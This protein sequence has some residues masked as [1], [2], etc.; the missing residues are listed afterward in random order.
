MLRMSWVCQGYL[1][2]DIATHT[3]PERLARKWSSPIYA[4]YHP[5]PEIEYKEGRRCHTFSC[6][7]KSCK[8]KCRRYLDKGD[9]NST[10]NLRKHV[11]TCWGEEALRAA[12]AT[13]SVKVARESVVKSLNETGSIT[14]AFERKGKGKVTYSNR[15]HTRTETRYAFVGRYPRAS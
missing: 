5:I 10:G 4:F 8:F 2:I 14:A 13:A 12:E 6:A 7:S 11:K 15:Q 3:G 1:P 9:S